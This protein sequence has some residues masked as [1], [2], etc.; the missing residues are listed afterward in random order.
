[1]VERGAKRLETLHTLERFAARIL[2]LQFIQ[3]WDCFPLQQQD[4]SYYTVHKRLSIAYLDRHLSG[5]LT[6]GTYLLSPTNTARFLVLDADTDQT[7]SDL[8]ALS[9][10][11]QAQGIPSYLEPSRRGGHLW[12]FFGQ[13]LQ[14]ALVRSFA[15][16]LLESFKL[17]RI[18]VYPKQDVL[19]TGPGSLIRLPFGVHRVSGERYPFLTSEGK[20]LGPTMAAQLHILRQPQTVNLGAI[21]QY[22][23]VVPK[24]QK[25]PVLTPSVSVEGQLSDRIKSAVTVYAFVSQ[26]VD[27]TEQGRGLCPFHDDRVMS[28]SVHKRKNYWHCFAGCGGGSIIDFWM[29]FRNCDFKT[30]IRELAAQL[31]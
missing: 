6:M 29:R 14:G 13:P 7:W 12:F 22:Q 10:K 25:K 27:L 3:R 18:E 28:L 11:L 31:L 17:N 16:G 20:E 2:E 26:Y 21:Q 4:G 9:P 1:M 30:A 15:F 24:E 19:D 8:R 23:L 5:E